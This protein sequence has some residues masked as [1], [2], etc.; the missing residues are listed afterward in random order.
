MAEPEQAALRSDASARAGLHELLYVYNGLVVV[1]L[2]GFMGITQEKVVSSMT[3]RA[4]LESLPAVPLPPVW[5]V[6]FSIG[7]FGTLFFLGWL[8]RQQAKKVL[9]LWRYG[10]MLGEISICMLLMWSLN[11]A[12]D[13]VVLLVVADLL[14]GYEGRHTRFILLLAMSGLY[15]IANY[16]LMASQLHAVPIEAYIS[17][18]N[19]SAQAALKSLLNIFTSL[20]IILFVLYVVVLVQSTHRENERIQSLNAQL[21]DANQRLMAYAL[22]AEHMAETR[23]RNRLAREIHDTLGHALT[24][25]AAGLDACMMTVETAPEFTKKQ[26]AKIR[27]TALR[28]IKDVRRSV[29]KLRPDDLE[30][31]SLREALF[32]M[33]EEFMASSGMEISY[34]ITGWPEQMREDEEEV[35]YRIVQESVTN[36]NRHGHARHVEITVSADEEWMRIVIADDGIG[37]EHVKKGFGLRHMQERLE[38]LKGTLN[39]WSDGG[40]ILEVAIPMHQPMVAEQGEE[41]YDSSDDR[42]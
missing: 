2:A 15:F 41:P 18:Y 20:N 13:G 1:L 42:G 12:Y 39:Y 9:R 35:V 8:Y 26:L 23:E 5:G 11:L 17:Y 21:H 22:E 30:R 32:K 33:T 4:F 37:C 40:F 28:G 16:W 10:L 19:A 36:A 29:K 38:L 14:H 6:L 7:A 24:G 31:L 3:A 27:E 25:I 34:T